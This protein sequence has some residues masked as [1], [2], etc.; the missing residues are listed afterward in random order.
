MLLKMLRQIVKDYSALGDTAANGESGVGNS[1]SPKGLLFHI[2][3]DNSADVTVLDIGFGAGS[4]GQLIK[5]NPA[6][7]H[8]IVDGV[9]GYA[10]HCNNRS[11]IERRIYRNLW[12]GYAHEISM[13]LVAQYKIICLLDV[14][15]HLTIDTAKWLLRTL[16]TALGEES[17][18]FVSTPLWFYPQE[19]FEDGDLEEHLIG[20][21][22]TSMMALNPKMYSINA[23]LVGGFVYDKQSLPFVDFFQPTSDRG[24][25]YEKGLIIAN[26]INLN[27]KEGE[28]VNLR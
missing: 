15:E 17:Y 19:H 26:A 24:F 23:P 1:C 9:D 12:H 22:A 16:I 2:L 4:L 5:L 10:P 14:I 28:F 8:W 6:T 3:A 18:L 7:S 27:C 11:L 25:S 13:E 21:P 20:V